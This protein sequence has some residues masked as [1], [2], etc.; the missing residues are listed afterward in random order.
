MTLVVPVPEKMQSLVAQ[1][2][3]PGLQLD[4]FVPSYSPTGAKLKFSEDIQKP[5]L[6]TFVRVNNRAD[7][8][9]AEWTGWHQRRRT[10]LQGL[11]AIRLCA[12][13]TGP[14][15]LH[16]A[17]ASAL[18]NAGIC[19]HPL[20]GFVYLPGT[21]LKGLAH[22]YASEV[23]LPA[24]S[25]REAGWKKICEV[26]GTAP[27]PFLN[28]LANRHGVPN[29]NMSAA[30]AV[31]FHDAWPM[32][33]PKVV[34]DILNSHHGDY[35]SAGLK[36]DANQEA[37]VPSPGDW[38]SPVPNYFLSVLPET[39]F[40]FALSPRR[41]DQTPTA[42]STDDSTSPMQLAAQW[43]V[44]GL[45]H[46]G[47]GAKTA[48]GYGGF[49]LV[50]APQAIPALSTAVAADWKHAVDRKQRVEFTTTLELQTPAFLAG[51]DQLSPD[52]CDLRPAT[53]RG[54]P[55][56][57]GYV[58][59]ATLAKLETI[60]WGN[61]RSGSPLSLHLT[62][63]LPKTPPQSYDQRAL[64]SLSDSQKSDKYG[65]PNAR[66]TTQGLWYITY[67]MDDKKKGRRNYVEPGASWSLTLG[68]ALRRGK[69]ATAPTLDPEMILDQA[70]SALYLLTRFG[71]VG[72]KSRKGFGSLLGTF[73]DDYTV[74][75][76][77][78]K[79]AAFRK[80]AG[81]ATRSTERIVES[82]AFGVDRS[83]EWEKDVEFN[84]PDLWA[85]LDQVGFALQTLAQKFQHSRAK[86]AI[87]LPR[88]PRDGANDSFRPTGEFQR[89]LGGKVD[90][91]RYASPL[92]FHLEQRNDRF[93]VRAVAFVQPGLPNAADSR[94]FLTECL[95]SL[96]ADLVRRSEL[97]VPAWAQK[98][99]RRSTAAPSRL[100]VPDI[101]IEV[102]KAR[103]KSLP[104]DREILMLRTVVDTRY[105]ADRVR[106]A[107]IPAGYQKDG[108]WFLIGGPDGLPEGTC[109]IALKP[110]SG[111]RSAKF[112]STIGR[113]PP[114]PPPSTARRGPPN[115]RR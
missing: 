102:L 56:H 103:L 31:V 23:W 68:V 25:D 5:A 18:E 11:Q 53:L 28:D 83:I 43:L 32:E 37:R 29:P 73:P 12:A 59:A 15:T 78:Q 3:H 1:N 96:H 84:W 26:F 61:A 109:V 55:L 14:F 69:G 42:P 50:E 63:N 111:S 66:K 95:T 41:L 58:D 87:G 9:Q 76:C 100:A 93:V 70:R 108:S 30:G 62:R 38:E 65:V 71:G 51:A 110:A 49:R 35:Y 34:M 21:G 113:V 52:G 88:V 77:L 40:D 79:S 54:L 90:D 101:T 98:S 112:E 44:G 17:R 46:L 20:Y 94:K 36:V 106:A 67:G 47:A 45:T 4:R 22:A 104:A 86:F 82:S 75:R 10:T 74:E 105:N 27:S 80:Q 39:A 72:A 99:P 91:A 48:A 57:A 19:L 85:V 97:P 81:F 114:P 6:E 89:S 16:L 8:A 2:T 24:Q 64:A 13:T 33:W 60:V 92:H 107:S 115:R 7:I